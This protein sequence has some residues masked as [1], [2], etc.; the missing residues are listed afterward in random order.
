MSGQAGTERDLHHRSQSSGFLSS[1]RGSSGLL[2]NSEM[3][4]DSFW[5]WKQTRGLPFCLLKGQSCRH[6]V[7]KWK[8]KR[9]SFGAKCFSSEP[10]RPLFKLSK[11]WASHPQFSSYS[12]S[13]L[14]LLFPHP[15]SLCLLVGM[16]VV[17]YQAELWQTVGWTL[18]DVGSVEESGNGLRARTL[19]CFKET[20]FKL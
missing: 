2:S 9:G 16:G 1:L 8:A 5:S 12:F 19:L 14:S 4:F 13:S 15:S 18:Q 10:S 17:I 20:T 3:C 11:S 7:W 6:K